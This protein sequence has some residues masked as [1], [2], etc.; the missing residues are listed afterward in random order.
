MGRGMFMPEFTSAIGDPDT[1]RGGHPNVH[2]TTGAGGI[3]LEVDKKTGKVRV[4]K[5]VLAADVGKALNPGL[6]RGQV[7]GGLLQGLATVLYEDMRFDDRGRLINPNFSDYKIPTALD[8][9]EE[10]VPIIVETAQP[11]GPYGARGV[12]EHT[13]IP[14]ASLVA[15]AVEDA[16]GVRIKGM[17]VT[18][19]KIALA[20]KSK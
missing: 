15:N 6:I 8:V 16:V 9:P 2:Y 1:G 19:E 5:A 13:M 7:T 11:D 17:P 3:V 20:I 12:G 18:A 10:I 4:L 14:A